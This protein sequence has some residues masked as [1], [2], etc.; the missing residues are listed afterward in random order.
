M[1]TQQATHHHNEPQKGGYTMPTEKEMK[2]IELA[3]LYELRLMIAA[4]E[5]ETYTKQELL[6]IL[7]KFA[8][9]KNMPV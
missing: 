3:T 4:D 5:K 2:K 8:M 6:E 1:R 7:D 9:V